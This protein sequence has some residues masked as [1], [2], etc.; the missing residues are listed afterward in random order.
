MRVYCGR[1]LKSVLCN[2][3][4]TIESFIFEPLNDPCSQLETHVKKRP[5]KFVLCVG[6]N[7]ENVL[8]F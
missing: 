2:L 4:C 7:K 1:N 8:N 3:V 5:C 6:G